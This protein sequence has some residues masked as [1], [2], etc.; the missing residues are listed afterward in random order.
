MIGKVIH[1]E[2]RGAKLGFQLQIYK[3]QNQNSFLK[4]VCIVDKPLLTKPHPAIIYIGTKPTFNHQ[5]LS[6]EVHILN[7][8]NQSIYGKYP[9]VLLESFI[10]D[11]IHFQSKTKLVNQ[12]NHDI[13]TALSNKNKTI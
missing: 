7:Q 13:K 12:I 9:K 4:L 2:G 5:K 1:G 10:R 8:F 11:D 3:Y 6:I